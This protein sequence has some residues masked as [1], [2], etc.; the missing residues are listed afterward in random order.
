MSRDGRHGIR[1]V[2][3]FVS[4]KC[5]AQG[6]DVVKGKCAVFETLVEGF[7]VLEEGFLAQDC[8]CIDGSA[9]EVFSS[10]L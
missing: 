9:T 6:N 1:A 5:G 10:P 2:D 3:A 8:Y 7:A 4:I